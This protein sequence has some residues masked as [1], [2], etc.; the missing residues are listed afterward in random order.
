M[1]LTVVSLLLYAYLVG[2][3]AAY[4]SSELANYH[5]VTDGF[6]ASVCFKQIVIK[7]LMYY[8]KVM[9]SCWP[10]LCYYCSGVA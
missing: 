8:D 7:L 3:P 9:N 4:S 6:V 10:I 5:K 2:V 1:N